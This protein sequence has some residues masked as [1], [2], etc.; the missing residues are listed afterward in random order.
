MS[1]T[2][3]IVAEL[4]YAQRD[5]TGVVNQILTG[6]AFA[7]VPSTENAAANEDLSIC[8]S[9]ANFAAAMARLTVEL[10]VMLSG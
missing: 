6:F 8:G 2:L 7:V 3:L 9:T 10:A 1:D 5:G 4:W